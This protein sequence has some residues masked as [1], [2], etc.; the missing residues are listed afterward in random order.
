MTFVAAITWAAAWAV[1]WKVAVAVLVIAFMIFTHELGHFFAAKK[2]GIKVD[3][4]SIG[5]GPEIFGWDRE[6]RGIR[7]SG[8]SRAV[9]SRSRE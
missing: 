1:I 3:Q 5:F 7:S 9:R 4:F 8:S 6:R 2:V